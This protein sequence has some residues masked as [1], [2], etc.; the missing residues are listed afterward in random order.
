MGVVLRHEDHHLQVLHPQVLRRTT[1]DLQQGYGKEHR[2][3]KSV[4]L[5]T[6]NKEER[7][8]DRLRKG[9]SD[10]MREFYSLYGSQLAKVCARYIADDDDMKDVFQDCLVRIFSHA[11]DFT[12][13]GS[14]SLQA[15]ATKV[16]VNES[17]KYLQERKRH[18]L[19]LLAH[20][21]PDEPEED[22]PPVQDIPP[23]V[24]Y[25]M[26]C[27]LPTGYRTVFNLYVFEEK[28]HQEIADLLG[29]KK[30][31]SASQLS[32]AKKWLAQRIR[33]YN[34]AKENPR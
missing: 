24:F 13:R 30:D 2:I 10:A 14:G 11:K 18:E 12:Y 1:H 22:D 9:D 3:D 6:A 8:A 16:A 29:I 21:V 23:E 28:S 4:R 20:D 31:S 33:E 15:W 34:N 7:L 32:R 5:L 27:E 17:L 26:V 19:M 25:Q